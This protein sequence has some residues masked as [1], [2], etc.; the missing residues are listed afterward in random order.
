MKGLKR[1]ELISVSCRLW[2]AKKTGVWGYLSAVLILIAMNLADSLEETFNE[3]LFF[4][5]EER[6]LASPGGVW[7]QSLLIHYL[8]LHV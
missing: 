6:F 5:L 2:A 7:R 8:C 3:G 4:F 1:F